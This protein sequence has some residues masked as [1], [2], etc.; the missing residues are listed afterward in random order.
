MKTKAIALLLTAT[1][2]V[3]CNSNPPRNSMQMQ[4][5]PSG[6]ALPNNSIKH[7]MGRSLSE[8]IS[9]RKLFI[10]AYRLDERKSLAANVLAAS[11]IEIYDD[12][13]INVDQVK[14]PYSLI[15]TASVMDRKAYGPAL[16][17]GGREN[18]LF[19]YRPRGWDNTRWLSF[20]RVAEKIGQIA[21]LKSGNYDLKP[22]EYFVPDSRYGKGAGYSYVGTALSNADCKRLGPSGKNAYPDCS[23]GLLWP[24]NMDKHIRYSPATAHQFRGV[25]PVHS[26]EFISPFY[27]PADYHAFAIGYFNTAGPNRVGADLDLVKVSQDWSKSLGET[28]YI[29]LAPGKYTLRGGNVGRVPVL[30]NNGKILLFG[31]QNPL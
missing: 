1:V 14:D 17:T 29:Y 26:P 2:L 27:E 25:L 7:D 15:Y 24:Q 20:D 16:R 12:R 5:A 23:L 28:A 13:R 4:S 10:R 9:A 8:S 19:Y 6:Q 3:G 30:I 11:Y 21:Q 22:V 31:K 18:M